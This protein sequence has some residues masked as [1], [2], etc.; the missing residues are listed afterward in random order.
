[1]KLVILLKP[2]STVTLIAVKQYTSTIISQ[3]HGKALGL[4][5]STGDP[6]K[7]EMYS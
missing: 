2:L 5:A 6:T 7:D 4:P 1:M 3:Y